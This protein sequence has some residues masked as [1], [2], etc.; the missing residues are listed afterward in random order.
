M[1]ITGGGTDYGSGPHDVIFPAG[2]TRVPINVSLTDDNMLEGN[3][4][5][6]L[7][8][9]PSSHVIVDYPGQAIVNILDQ[10]GK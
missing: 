10:S 2:M 8:I 9:H 3:E 1:I 6:I 7:T 4:H 5:F